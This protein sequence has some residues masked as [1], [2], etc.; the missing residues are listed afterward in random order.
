MHTL[1]YSVSL[2]KAEHIPILEMYVMP[3]LL[4]SKQDVGQ[5]G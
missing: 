1:K 2:E 3:T 4:H 5:E